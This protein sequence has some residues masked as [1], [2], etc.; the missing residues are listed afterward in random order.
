VRKSRIR[1]IKSNDHKAA[2]ILHKDSAQGLFYIPGLLDGNAFLSFLLL[3][4]LNGLKL[5]LPDESI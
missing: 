4:Y 5:R 1:T 3:S 2:R